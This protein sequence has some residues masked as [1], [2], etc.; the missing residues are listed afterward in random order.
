M[1]VRRPSVQSDLFKPPRQLNIAADRLARL[2]D[3]ETDE[4]DLKAVAQEAKRVENNPLFAVR[5]GQDVVDFVDDENLHADRFHNSQGG[6]LH[7]RDVGAWSLRRAEERQQFRVEPAF[8]RSASH[9]HREYGRCQSSFVG[10]KARRM[11]VPKLLHDHRFA[12]TAVAIDSNRRHASP[13]RIVEQLAQT[14]ERLFG[15]RV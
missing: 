3:P 15:S 13:P 9:L 4:R 6:L 14:V 8:S 11:I 1:F 10:I 5:T 2:I 12:H 7:L